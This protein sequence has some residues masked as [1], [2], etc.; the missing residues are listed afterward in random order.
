MSKEVGKRRKQKVKKG[1][2][3][4]SKEMILMGANFGPYYSTQF[5]STHKKMFSK[6]KFICFRD[7]IF[8]EVI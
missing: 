8:A 4:I 3:N 6:Y 2:L 5:L 7:R 1:Y